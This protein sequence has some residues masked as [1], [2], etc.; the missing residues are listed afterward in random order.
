MITRNADA[1]AHRG[2]TSSPESNVVEQ[3]VVIQ[4]TRVSRLAKKSE[5]TKGRVQKTEKVKQKRGKL[6]ND[7]T[8]E[9]GHVQEERY[10]RTHLPLD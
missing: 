1:Q 5:Q 10:M 3:V 9:K 8:S 2:S 6:P 4:G 7:E